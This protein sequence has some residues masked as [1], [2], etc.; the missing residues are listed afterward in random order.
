[1]N[2]NVPV[3]LIEILLKNV[4]VGEQISIGKSNAFSS[5]DFNQVMDLISLGVIGKLMEV[6]TSDGTTVEIWVE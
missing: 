6:E 5:I 2:V 4:N 3:A 1:M